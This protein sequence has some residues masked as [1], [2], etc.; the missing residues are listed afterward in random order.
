MQ[1]CEKKNREFTILPKGYWNK[2][3]ERENKGEGNKGGKEEIFGEK[4]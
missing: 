2:V 4:M 1:Y 3:K